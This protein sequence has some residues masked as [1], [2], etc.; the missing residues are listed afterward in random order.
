[1]SFVPSLVLALVAHQGQAAVSLGRVYT[2]NEQLTYS[3]RSGITAERRARG[4]ETWIPED[5]D[6][7]Y[8]FTVH[9]EALKADGIAVVRYKRP[10]MEEITGETFTSPPQTKRDKVNYDF[11]LTVSPF[12]EIVD[13][14][15]LAPKKKPGATKGESLFIGATTARQGL[16]AFLGQFIGELHRLALFTGNM[17]S[18]L[19]LAPRTSFDDVKVG[20]TWKRTVGYQPQKLKGKDGKNAV[21][22]L[23]Y[24]YTYKGLVNGEKG[25]V[26]R[27]E[28]KLNFATDLAEFIHQLSESTPAETGLQKLP[29]NLD[30]TILFDLDPKTK[31]TLKAEAT[32]VG[33][34]QIMTPDNPDAAYEERMKGHTTLRL[35]SRTIVAPAKKTAEKKK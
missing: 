6:I 22:R 33:S 4:L 5:F 27:V 10:Y 26:L 28:A 18:A 25:K 30:A 24:T 35:V 15:D 21:Q 29:L 19:D 8:D 14:K 13:M 16:G 34:F 23:D 9:V 17:E 1:M 20:D 3:V 11:R 7:N 31:H 32:S 2:P 12:N